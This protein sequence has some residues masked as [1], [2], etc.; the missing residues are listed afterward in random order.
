MKPVVTII[1]GITLLIFAESV[2]AQAPEGK[3]LPVSEAVALAKNNLQ[4]Q[5][6]IEQINKGKI[7]VNTATVL[8]KT[9]LFAENEDMRPSDNKGILKVGVSQSIVWPGLYKAQKN[10]YKEELKYWQSSTAAID[11]EIK[12]DVRSVYYQ[13]WYLQ[14]KQKLF[15]RLDS[16]YRS[17]NAAAILKVK[18]GDSPG[19]DSIA[20]NVRMQELQAL[21]RQINN[22]ISI[23]QQLMMQFVNS[24]DKLLPLMIP[25]EKLSMPGPGNDSVHP[26]LSLQSQN[27][28]IANAGIAVMRN[29]NKP[30]FSGRFFSQRLWGAKDPV[31]GF[32]VS[33]AFPLFGAGAYK[34]KVKLAQAE[35]A[36][37]QKQYEY[38][39]R[40]FTTQQAQA[41]Q[42]VYRNNSLLA[43]YES[44][45]L[46]QAEE[47]IKASSLAYRAGEISYAEFSQF[48]AQAIEIQK[49]Y[50]DNL[51]AYN[52][53]VIQYYYYVNQ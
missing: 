11:A 40:V 23:Q 1:A 30:E 8:P 53:S 19:L 9:G 39:K 20:A 44:T 52:Q 28:N 51:N 37:Q 24:N 13:L 12:R 46:K 38:G 49:N 41:Q 29:E 4:Y 16:I 31:S 34:N 3:R 47:I 27:I 25:L 17:M 43:F 35:L 48:L 7:Q 36:V 32:S 33:A 26:V 6:N 14:D 10:L 18:T 2:Q 45:G 50:L 22:D 21:L 5:V 15:Q 42:E